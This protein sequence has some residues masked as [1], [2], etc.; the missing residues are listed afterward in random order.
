[1]NVIQ[2]ADILSIKASRLASLSDDDSINLSQQLKMLVGQNPAITDKVTAQFTEALQQHRDAFQEVMS[3]R[4]LVNFFAQKDYARSEFPH[5]LPFRDNRNTR[6]FVELYLADELQEMIA[7]K[8]DDNDF[9]ILASMAKLQGFFPESISQILVQNLYTKLDLATQAL[10]PPYSDFSKIAYLRDVNFFD[11]TNEFK[12]ILME[13]KVKKLFIALKNWYYLHNN[14]ELAKFSFAAMKQYVAIDPIFSEQIIQFKNESES[15]YQPFVVNKSKHKWVYFLIGI[16]FCLQLSFLYHRFADLDFNSDPQTYD[17]YTEAPELDPYYTN[18]K[19]KI[20]SF[21]VFLLDYNPKEIRRLS[22]ITSVKTGQNP[23]ETFYEYP[24]TGES[25]NNL[26]VANESAYDMIL[27]ENAVMY[28]S[29][30]IPRAAHFI[31]T[32]DYNYIHFS[33]D[34]VRSV[35]N[36]YVG[37]KLATFQTESN[38]LFVRNGSVVEYRFSELAPNAKAILAEDYDFK[39]DVKLQYRN[40]KLALD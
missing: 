37:K 27:L 24:P 30:K 17:D 29:I 2:A 28:D 7:Q 26:R 34:D 38:H 13:D 10:T 12:S 36:V 4:I 25:S 20:D 8:M 32:G 9:E 3:H 6:L 31:K 16:V 23:F 21:Q 1:M 14:S 40:G 35:F 11:L 5:P 18:M 22:L 33:R 39:N 19:Y 15:R